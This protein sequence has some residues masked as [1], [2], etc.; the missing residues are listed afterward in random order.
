MLLYQ[1]F[2]YEHT[3]HLKIKKKKLLN[4]INSM[5]DRQGMV[6]SRR[7]SQSGE[8]QIGDIRIMA[9]CLTQRSEVAMKQQKMPL[10]N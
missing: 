7:G 3:P 5:T 10:G 8:L 9:E 2:R 4:S 6:V 1:L